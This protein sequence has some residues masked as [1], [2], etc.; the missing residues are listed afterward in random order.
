MTIRENYVAIKDFMTANGAAAELVE[1]V[2]SRIAQEDKA[3]ETAKAKRLEKNGG[4]KKDATQSEF[5]T[6][7]REKLYKS[8]TT[9]FQTGADLVA[10]AAVTTPAGKAVLAAQ[11]AMALKPLIEDGSVIC[12]SVKVSYVDKQG[13]NKESMR[14]AYKLA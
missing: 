11:V 7:L 4:E 12:D 13:L 2:E 3:R 9:E 1:F 14:K 8:L 5:Y 10:K 6:D